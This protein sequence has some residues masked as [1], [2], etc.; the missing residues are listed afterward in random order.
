MP[1]AAVAPAP[2]QCSYSTENGGGSAKEGAV[3]RREV[4]K[5][6]D[7]DDD[8]SGCDGYDRKDGEDDE[9]DMGGDRVGDDGN[10]EE[11]NEAEALMTY[12]R[13]QHDIDANDRMKSSV[14]KSMT[15]HG[16]NSGKWPSAVHTVCTRRALSMANRIS[17]PSLDLGSKYR[18][19]MTPM[20]CLCLKKK[21]KKKKK[22]K[23][24]ERSREVVGYMGIEFKAT[25]W[26]ASVAFVVFS[27]DGR[28]DVA[29]GEIPFPQVGSVTDD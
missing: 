13:G 19:M 3:C 28:S 17:A 21:A 5:R 4:A 6:E 12:C 8:D 18:E 25:N 11:S 9:R 26:K 23:T 1:V 7:D 2:E 10:E 14:L 22:K 20:F 15:F 24:S 27:V 29:K 16:V